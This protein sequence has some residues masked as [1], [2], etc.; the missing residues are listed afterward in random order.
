MKN[1]I[2]LLGL[3]LLSSNTFANKPG[4]PSEP[5]WAQERYSEDKNSRFY[6]GYFSSSLL[7]SDAID[8]AEKDAIES[9]IKD[10][11]GVYTQIQN[12]SVGTLETVQVK[13]QKREK[14]STLL[15]KGVRKLKVF[16]RSNQDGFIAWVQIQV[17][18]EKTALVVKQLEMESKDQAKAVIQ[19][20]FEDTEKKD[21]SLSKC[22]AFNGKKYRKVYKGMSVQEFVKYYGIPSSVEKQYSGEVRYTYS[23]HYFCEPSSYSRYCSVTFTNNQADDFYKFNPHFVDLLGI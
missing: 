13:N 17:A 7:E 19:S 10:C 22:L 9:Y 23:N 20:N 5:G 3:L 15:L 2:L 18:K 12:D 6:V 16:T 14:S 21:G 8:L 1:G 11:F 4:L